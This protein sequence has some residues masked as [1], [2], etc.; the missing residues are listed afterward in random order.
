MLESPTVTDHAQSIDPHPFGSEPEPPLRDQ[1]ELEL[2]FVRACKPRHL[3]RVG[4]EAEKF[5]VDAKSGAPLHYPGTLGVEGILHNLIDRHGWH[6]E[7]EYP[8]GPLIALRRGEASV[9]L[10]PGASSS[11]RAR[12]C[13]TCTRSRASS[14]RT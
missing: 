6:E 12:P 13:P 10:E 4:A 7:A 2:I 1:S 8:N 5:G 3:W 9:T 14:C 11:C